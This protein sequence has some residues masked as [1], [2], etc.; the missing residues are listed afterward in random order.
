MIL[1]FGIAAILALIFFPRFS[2]YQRLLSEQESLKRKIRELEREN[3]RLK[4]EQY[5]LQHDIEYV[6]E[7]AREKL[8]IVRKNEIPYKI[9]EEKGGE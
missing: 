7:V 2:R 9:I 6:E 5:R 8:G 1:Y 3:K 4:E